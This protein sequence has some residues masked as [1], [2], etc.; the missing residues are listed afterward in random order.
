MSELRLPSLSSFRLTST[1]GVDLDRTRRANTFAAHRLLHFAETRGHQGELKE[2]MLAAYFTE[3]RWLA[4][5]DV[6]VELCTA[7]GLAGDEARAVLSSDLFSDDVRAD[8]KVAAQLGA[9]GVP[10]FVIDRRYGVSGAQ[11]AT[12][13]AEILQ[14][15]WAESHE[16]EAM[17]AATGAGEAGAAGTAGADNA[18]DGPGPLP[19]E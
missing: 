6:L 3:G 16:P 5:D 7:V 10:F 4:D 14:R 13:F 12:V 8:E 1:P 11:D 2:A 17:S 18:A 15:A 19:H 9:T